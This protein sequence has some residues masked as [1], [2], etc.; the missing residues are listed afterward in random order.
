MPKRR[1][2]F[3][4]GGQEVAPGRRARVEIPVARLPTGN[5][6]NLPVT[7]FHG[8]HDGAVLWLS[9]AIHGNEINGIEVIRRVCATLD[10]RGL[11]GTVMAIP[12]VNVFGFINQSRYLPDR[13]DLNRV[14]PGS[15]RGSLASRLASLFMD[16]VVSK[17]GYGIDLHTGGRDRNNLPQI[18]TNLDDAETCA[19]AEAFGAPVIINANLRD[20]SLRQTAGA[21]GRHV[22]LYEGGEGLRFNPEAI[23]VGVRGVRRVMNHLGMLEEPDGDIAPAYRPARTSWLRAHRGGL[24]HLN[25]TLGQR[26]KKGDY[27]GAIQDAFGKDRAVVRAPENG[28]VIGHATN[29]VVHQGDATVNLG[30]DA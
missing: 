1:A 7:V 5:M 19:L 6:E 11:R 8:R 25:I 28:M 13:R 17:C 23:D 26:V 20:G 21:M 4:V 22:L 30:L 15:K 27:L 24:L 9:A 3:M 16:E 2:P 14:F 12:V 29:P 10:P 18:R